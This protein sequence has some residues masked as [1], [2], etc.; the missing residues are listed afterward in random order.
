MGTGGQKGR[1]GYGEAIPGSMQV[2]VLI[3]M[4]PKEL[5]D[6]AFQLRKDREELVYKEVRGRVL[7]VAMNRVQ[8]RIPQMGKSVYGIGEG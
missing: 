8:E 6:I 1:G 7:G 4:L 2:A 5:Q 3:S